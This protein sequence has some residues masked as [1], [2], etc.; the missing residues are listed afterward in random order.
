MSSIKDVEKMDR[1]IRKLPN[2]YEP[3][4]FRQATEA[5]QGLRKAFDTSAYRQATEAA[6][7]LSEAFDTSAYRQATEAAQRLSKAFDTSAYRQATEAV[8]RLRKAFDTSAYRQATEAVQKL[9]EAFDTSAYRQAT[10][11]VQ[12]LGKAFDTSTYRQISNLAERLKGITNGFQDNGY[13][14]AVVVA[15]IDYL[16]NTK[17]LENVVETKDYYEEQLEI[18]VECYTTLIAHLQ[19]LWNVITTEKAKDIMTVAGFIISVV[20]FIITIKGVVPNDKE[21]MPQ[22]H[23]HNYSDNVEIDTKIEDNKVEIYIEEKEI[24]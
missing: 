15:G 8:Q 11:A 3:T 7:R 4:A 13:Y 21:Q 12:R 14:F 5:V 20:G 18:L 1:Q 19:K 22:I 16:E 23:I 9:S 10:E 6:Q 17:N 24:E 2:T